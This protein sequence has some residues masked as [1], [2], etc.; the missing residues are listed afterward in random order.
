[1]GKCKGTGWR[2]IREYFVERFGED[3]VGKVLASMSGEDRGALSAPILN[4]SWIHDG[5]FIRFLLAADRVLGQGDQQLAK[6]SVRYE[7]RKSFGGIYKIFLAVST[8]QFL[9]SNAAN[10]W[11]QY[12]DTGK[13]SVRTVDKKKV[14]VQISEYPDIPLHH[15]IDHGTTFEE[16][17]SLCGVKNSVCT[18][19][20]CIARGDD[21]CLFEITW[22]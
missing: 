18:Q 4:I 12:H 14:Q 22:S 13:V 11:R 2:G 3:A 5:A 6:E 7:V 15:E 19:P 10:V 21:R 20:K 16:L 9:I 17:A 1:M 8:P